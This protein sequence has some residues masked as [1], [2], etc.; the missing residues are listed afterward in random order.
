MSKFEITKDGIVL[1]N[2]IAVHRVTSASIKNITPDGDMEVELHFMASRVDVSYPPTK[3]K[4]S[5]P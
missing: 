5:H 3:Q 4:E 1:I 2:D